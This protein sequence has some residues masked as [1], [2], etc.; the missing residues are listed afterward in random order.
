MRSNLTVAR[1]VAQLRKA[2]YGN[3]TG[4]V[5]LFVEVMHCASGTGNPEVMDLNSSVACVWA[6]RHIFNQTTHKHR[7]FSVL[8]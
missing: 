1:L 3:F 2:L 4:L 8:C 5:R 7:C 6:C